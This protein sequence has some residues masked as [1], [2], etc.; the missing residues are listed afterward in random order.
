LWEV[1]AAGV[2]AVLA[3]RTIAYLQFYPAWSNV[4]FYVLSPFRAD[5]LLL[6]VLAAILVR[7]PGRLA[8]VRERRRAL[9]LTGAALGAV[10]AFFT[11]KGWGLL[12][13]AMS[14]AGHSTGSLLSDP[15]ALTITSSGWLK[16][17]FTGAHCAGWGHCLWLVLDP[18]SGARPRVPVRHR[19]PTFTHAFDLLPLTLA[20]VG[21]LLLAHL[22]WT[23]FESRLVRYG[24]RFAYEEHKSSGLV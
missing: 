8:F 6:G 4:A 20:L 22:S 5:G 21:S 18:C 13:T 15:L 14:T 10:L 3:F 17:I 12:S 16:R 11:W 24:H 9:M 1:A 2:I 23:L 7:N 19:G